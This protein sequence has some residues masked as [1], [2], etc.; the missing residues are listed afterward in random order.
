[1]P[2]WSIRDLWGKLTEK[3]ALKPEVRDTLMSLDGIYHQP[4]SKGVRPASDREQ[5]AETSPKTSAG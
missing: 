3:K 1:M 5:P 4:S 2:K